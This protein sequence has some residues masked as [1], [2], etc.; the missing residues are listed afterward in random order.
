MVTQ[1]LGALNDN[2]FKLAVSILIVRTMVSETG[3]TYLVSLSG[4]LFVL[5]FV[6]LAPLA[7]YLSDRFSKTVITRAIKILEL[8]IML[9]AAVA[10]SIG[11][12]YALLFILFL[13]GSQSALFSPS[14]YGILPEMLRESEL[15]RANGFI[16]FWTFVAILLGTALGGPLMSWS[17]DR[18]GIVSL[19]VITLAATGVVSSLWI[20]PIPAAQP[21]KAFEWNGFKAVGITLRAVGRHP[22]LRPAFA[23]A[24]FFWFSGAYVQLNS[25]LYATQIL[26]LDNMGLSV[27]LTT[28]ALGI[29]IGSLMAGKISAHEID[30]RSVVP[31]CLSMALFA[32]ALCFTQKQLLLAAAWMFGMGFSGGLFIVPLN[33]LIQRDSPAEE[34]G[35]YLAALA[36]LTSLSMMVASGAIWLFKDPVGLNGAMMFCVIGFMAVAVAFYLYRRM[37]ESTPFGN[38][39]ASA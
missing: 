14:K 39:G 11:N 33:A 6:L 4:A 8:A 29:G 19:A 35:S 31:G 10:F 21:Q 17:G 5:P 26:K 36:C 24:C 27:L 13:M 30:L 1:F 23:G 28:L 16:Q 20:K 7:G 12:A 2:V 37:P 34:R 25:L 15:G 32:G 22:R 38:C 9:T 18:Y 3:G